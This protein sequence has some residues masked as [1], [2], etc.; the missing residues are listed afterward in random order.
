MNE[1]I[2][3]IVPALTDQAGQCRIVRYTGAKSIKDPLT[4]YRTYPEQWFE[5]GIMSSRGSLVCYSG[6]DD[7]I[8]ALIEDVPLA[9]GVIYRFP[10]E[11]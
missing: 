6:E 11:S 3:L 7:E 1:R 4:H 2:V 8:D 5:A 10:S 9:A